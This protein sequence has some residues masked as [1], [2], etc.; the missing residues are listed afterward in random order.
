MYKGLK[1]VALTLFV[2]VGLYTLLGFLILPGVGLRVINQQLA[3]YA[4]VPA[5]LDRLQF[6]PYSLQLTLWGLH[7][8][9]GGKRASCV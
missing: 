1:Y 8:G 6:N 5:R 7:V 4:Q 3:N 9:E 2:L